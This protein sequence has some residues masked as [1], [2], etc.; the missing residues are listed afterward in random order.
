MRATIGDFFGYVQMILFLIN[1]NN[2][3][4]ESERNASD[5]Y[6]EGAMPGIQIVAYNRH[7]TPIAISPQQ[8]FPITDQ[9]TT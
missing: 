5:K 8:F 2:T 3:M 6:S 1:C 7:M 9:S 4:E